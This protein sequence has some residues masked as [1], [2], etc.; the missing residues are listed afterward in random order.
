MLRRILASAAIAA[1]LTMLVTAGSAQARPAVQSTTCSLSSILTF[2]PGLTFTAVDQTIKARGTLDSC[3][4]GGVSSGTLRGRGGGTL[5]CTSGMAKAK[6]IITWD[7]SE[8][9]TVKLRADVSSGTVT[10]KVVAGKFSGEP[11]TGDL[12]LTPIEGDCFS[13]PVTKA[14]AEGPVSL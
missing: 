7:T 11:A 9:S 8:T 2:S 14:S 10:G 6:A 13:S 3:S 1:S 5:S 12:T 4:G